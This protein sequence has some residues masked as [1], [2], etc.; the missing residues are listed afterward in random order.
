MK[1]KMKNEERAK[2]Y[3]HLTALNVT[4]KKGNAQAWTELS[5]TLY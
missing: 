4:E 1:Y 3:D 2:K 5:S